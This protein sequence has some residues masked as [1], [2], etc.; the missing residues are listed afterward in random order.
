MAEG[1]DRSGSPHGYRRLYCGN[2]GQPIDVPIHCSS[3]TCSYCATARKWRT[4]HRLRGLLQHNP[5][6]GHARWQHFVFTVRNTVYLLDGVDLLIRSFRL[7]RHHPAWKTRQFG[8]AYVV[9]ITKSDRG[10]HP[11]LHVISYGFFQN[12]KVIRRLWCRYTGA[13]HIFVRPIEGNNI[14]GYFVKYMAKVPKLPEHDLETIDRELKNRR[15]FAHFGT[16]NELKNRYKSQNFVPACRYCGCTKW[17]P[18]FMVDQF[19]AWFPVKPHTP[20]I[21]GP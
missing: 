21:H 3:K 4:Y 16:L 6:I 13:Y 1:Y 19:R 18:D 20:S 8:G 2:C 5:Q 9:E 14:A 17:I 15:L 11:H 10:W 7:L 12:A